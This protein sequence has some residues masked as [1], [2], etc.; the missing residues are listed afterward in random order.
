MRIPPMSA[1]QS[2]SRSKPETLTVAAKCGK[3]NDR[4]IRLWRQR[5]RKGE[6][7]FATF[8][9]ELELAK[10]T[11]ISQAIDVIRNAGPKH[12]QA[13]AW[14]LERMYPDLFGSQAVKMAIIEMQNQQMQD[15]LEL[16]QR[17]ESSLIQELTALKSNPIIARLCAGPINGDGAS[18]PAPEG[19]LVDGKNGT[20]G[21]VP[22]TNGNGYHPPESGTNGTSH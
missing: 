20:N 7:P 16:S 11:A 14:W 9:A 19:G 22:G 5:A 6:E 1:L 18:T 8:F 21:H 15:A 12:W 13:A 4:T 17:R 3:I 10:G 2:Y